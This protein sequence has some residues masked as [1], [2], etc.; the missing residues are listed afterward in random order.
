MV[1]VKQ[2]EKKSELKKFVTFPFSLYKDSPYWVP[3]MIK[4]EM[5]SF[6][7]TKNPAFKNA[8]ACFFLAYK[9]GKS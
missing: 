9:D 7:K 1:T 3:P 6:D 5:E 4:D 8:D 2:A